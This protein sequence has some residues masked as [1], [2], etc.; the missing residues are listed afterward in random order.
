MFLFTFSYPSHLKPTVLKCFL[1]NDLPKTHSKTIISLR[2]SLK[3]VEK[4]S[5]DS[6]GGTRR[7]GG[8][9]QL[10]EAL[11]ELREALGELWEGQEELW[12]ALSLSLYIYI[13]ICRERD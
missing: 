9:G 6:S 5:G 1:D 8:L 7:R 11:A 2:R 13:Y 3:K 12:E 4:T 10:W